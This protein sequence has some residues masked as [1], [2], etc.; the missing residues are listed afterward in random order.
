M[1]ILSISEAA[2]L[3]GIDRRTLQRQIARGAVSVVAGHDGS[4]GIE[5]SELEPIR[6]TPF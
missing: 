3:A 4:R 2:R 5:L 6:I 1:P